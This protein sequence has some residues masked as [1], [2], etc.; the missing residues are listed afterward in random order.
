[1]V[2]LFCNTNTSTIVGFLEDDDVLPHGIIYETDE[3]A[4]IVRDPSKAFIIVCSN[5]SKMTKIRNILMSYFESSSDSSIGESSNDSYSDSSDQYNNSFRSPKSP[6][7][8]RPSS[9]D[10][11][12]DFRP[13]SISVRKQRRRRR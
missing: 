1:M 7:S 11:S 6:M 9:S 2:K 3:S 5:R 12:N 10:S 8:S 4:R 13:R